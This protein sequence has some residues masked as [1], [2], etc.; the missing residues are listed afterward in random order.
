MLSLPRVRIVQRHLF[1]FLPTL[2]TAHMLN[3]NAEHV[4]SKIRTNITTVAIGLFLVIVLDLP[5]DIIL[6]DYSKSRDVG[7][8][9]GMQKDFQWTDGLIIYTNKG[10]DL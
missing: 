6:G 8:I 9:G 3:G 4:A 7:E 2:V 10:N 5:L 1:V